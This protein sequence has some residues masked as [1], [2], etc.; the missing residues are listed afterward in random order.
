MI[1]NKAK[2][3]PETSVTHQGNNAGFYSETKPEPDEEIATCGVFLLLA[4]SILAASLG[5]CSCAF[6]R[7]LIWLPQA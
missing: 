7:F 3:S 2:W 1:E 4:L 5:F 6:F